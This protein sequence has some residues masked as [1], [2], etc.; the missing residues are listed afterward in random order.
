MHWCHRATVLLTLVLLLTNYVLTWVVEFKVLILALTTLVLLSP[1][2]YPVLLLYLLTAVPTLLLSW[3]CGTLPQYLILFLRS[4][5]LTVVTGLVFLHRYPTALLLITSTLLPPQYYAV[6]VQC[7]K[8]AEYLRTQV[9]IL[10]FLEPRLR[11]LLPLLLTA[12][13]E[14][15]RDTTHLQLLA[16]QVRL[17]SRGVSVSSRVLLP[18]LLRLLVLPL[19]TT[20]V[21]F[22]GQY[23]SLIHI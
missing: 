6:L 4:L 5:L 18:V 14:Y 1:Y 15:L 8:V 3:C 19:L 9:P 13:V 2:T 17:R 11:Y 12:C 16:H 20:C 22:L 10:R 23:L 7:L 21:Q